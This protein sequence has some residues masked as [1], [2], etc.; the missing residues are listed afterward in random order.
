MNKLEVAR[1]QAR[2]AGTRGVCET[3]SPD[4]AALHGPGQFLD[5]YAVLPSPGYP[6]VRHLHKAQQV[7]SDTMQVDW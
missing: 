4:S 5:C 3:S 6:I 1:V 7:D 2:R